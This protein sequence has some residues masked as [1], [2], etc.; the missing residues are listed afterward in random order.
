MSRLIADPELR[1]K[2]ATAGR[3][4]AVSRFDR[5]GLAERWEQIYSTEL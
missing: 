3:A 5:N 1:A 4:S 2:L